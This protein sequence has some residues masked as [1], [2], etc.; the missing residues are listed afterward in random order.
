MPARLSRLVVLLAAATLFAVGAWAQLAPD[1]ALLQFARDVGLRDAAGFAETI[2][3]LRASGKLPAR[4]LT[5]TQAERRGWR[6]GRDLCRSSQGA[7]IGGDR[8]GN[9]ERLLPSAA[10][11]TW[12]EADLDFDCGERGASRLVWSN[13]GLYFVTVDHYRSFR[14][15]P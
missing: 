8:F 11:R 7:S 10:Q 5:K 4:Y 6:P 3:S 1:A 12:R 9:R 14:R 15:V 2:T 13:D